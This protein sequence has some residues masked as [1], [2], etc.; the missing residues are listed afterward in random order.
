MIVNTFKE[1]HKHNVR[2]FYVAL[3]ERSLNK[4]VPNSC[5]NIHEQKV[6]INF[7]EE[8]LILAK[9]YVCK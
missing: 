8:E 7:S 1:L 5:E 2:P 9:I 6:S 3:F 4:G